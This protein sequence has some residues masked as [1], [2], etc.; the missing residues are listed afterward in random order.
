LGSNFGYSVGAR[1]ALIAC[2][3]HIDVVGNT[4]VHDALI[5]GCNDYLCCRNCFEALLITSLHDCFAAKIGKRLARK[6]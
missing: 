5:F 6:S 2:H 4:K 3:G 1:D